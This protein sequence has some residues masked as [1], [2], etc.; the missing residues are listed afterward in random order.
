M[1]LVDL[2]NS[3]N[4]QSQ[5]SN[6]NGGWNQFVRDHL[7]IIQNNSQTFTITPELMYRYRY[8]LNSFL[9]NSILKRNEDIGWIVCLLNEIPSSFEFDDI[10]SLIVPTDAYIRKLYL[11]YTT[12]TANAN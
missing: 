2:L 7:D 12:V 8:D 5:V 10:P 1:S 4:T 11:L 9:K 3:A 6:D